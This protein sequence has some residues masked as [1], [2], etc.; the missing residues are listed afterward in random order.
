MTELA[1]SFDDPSVDSSKHWYVIF[2]DDTMLVDNKAPGEESGWHRLRRYLEKDP[3]KIKKFGL[4]FKGQGVTI[5]GRELEEA[6]G[7]FYFSTAI[8]LMGSWEDIEKSIGVVKN[9]IASVDTIS[10]NGIEHRSI[11]LIENDPRFIKV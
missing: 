11:G 4:C 3:Q 1:T 5:Q 8:V 6:D 10:K 2:N 9:G 7:I